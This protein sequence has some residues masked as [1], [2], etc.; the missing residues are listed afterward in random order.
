MRLDRGRHREVG[1]R[2]ARALPA[3]ALG[4]AT[5]RRRS[6]TRSTSGVDPVLV[7]RPRPEEPG[8]LRRA[9]PLV[10][11]A[12]VDVGAERL[13]VERQ[14]PGSV[15]AVDDREHAGLAR[16]RADLRDREHERRRRG[17]VAD[18]DG[19]RARPDRADQLVRL[20]VDELAR[21]RTPTCASRRRT[22]AASSAP[23]RRAPS[24]SER[25]TA[26]SPAV[27]FGTKTRSSARAPTNAASAAR[28]SPDQ[29]VEAAPEELDR[30]ALELALQRLV[31]LEDR[32][33]AR[34]VAAVVEERDLRVEQ[35]IQVAT[36]SRC[37]ASSPA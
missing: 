5:S 28:A 37:A 15:R 22:R 19:L 26:F 25:M 21:R 9:E 4:E 30:V 18:G 14:L 20:D 3:V 23:R 17:D 35:E 16:R 11:V 6:P 1:R 12:R 8:A 13:Q 7:L 33:R 32:R 29:L 24:R 36:V 34:A 27:A 31:A 10:A 2:I